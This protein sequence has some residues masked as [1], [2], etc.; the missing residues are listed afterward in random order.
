M[1]EKAQGQLELLLLAAVVVVI[2]SGTAIFI[3][4]VAS[5]GSDAISDATQT[6]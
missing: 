3:K 6:E 2:A 5:A 4:S 1:E